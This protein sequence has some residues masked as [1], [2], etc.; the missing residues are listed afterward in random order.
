MARN[1]KANTFVKYVG[2]SDNRVLSKEDLAALGIEYDS[3]LAWTPENDWTVEVTSGAAEL[4]VAS[5]AREFVEVLDR[6]D[7]V[8]EQ[9]EG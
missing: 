3:G 5:E 4:L 2:T 1:K 8:P 9:P 7:E 6:D